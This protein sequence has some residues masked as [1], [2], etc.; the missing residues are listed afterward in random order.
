M[1]YV[2][3]IIIFRRRG[4]EK[5]LFFFFFFFFFIYIIMSFGICTSSEVLTASRS[6]YCETSWCLFC[7]YI[8]ISK[9]N[10]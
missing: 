10:K 7:I 1:Y 5:G 4:K 6:W 8:C 9:M 3:I 2:I